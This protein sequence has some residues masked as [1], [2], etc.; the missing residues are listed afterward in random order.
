MKP[1]PEAVVDHFANYDPSPEDV[2]SVVGLVQ[3]LLQNPDFGT[4]IPFADEKYRDCYVAL[5]PDERWRVVYRPVKPQG[6]VI[7]AIDQQDR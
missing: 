4:R 3:Q 1:I 2:K 6:I 7:V 5:T